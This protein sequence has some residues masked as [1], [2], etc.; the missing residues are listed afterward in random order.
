VL[1]ALAR[2]PLVVTVSLLSVRG[3]LVSRRVVW[4]KG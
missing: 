1:Q 4:K 3:L 2:P